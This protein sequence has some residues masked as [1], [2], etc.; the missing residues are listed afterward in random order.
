VRHQ[1]NPVAVLAAVAVAGLCVL[2][3]TPASAQPHRGRV[4]GAVVVG[5]FYDP[6]FFN[7]FF[8]PFAYGWG[9]PYEAYGPYGVY[10]YGRPM[11]ETASARL[12]VTPKEAEVFVDGYKA[13]RVDDFDGAFQR[14]NVAPGPHEITLFR[15]GY[16]TVTEKLYLSEGSTFK[17]RETMVKLAPGEKSEPPPVPPAPRRRSR[18]RA[19][20]EDD[21]GRDDRGAERD[22]R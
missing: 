9:Y 15:D 17:V 6:F 1:G 22:R 20:A 19:G 3:P 14:L 11:A 21:D 13:G 10:G 7:P 8:S 18:E 4:H 2:S 12:L 16:R 5:G